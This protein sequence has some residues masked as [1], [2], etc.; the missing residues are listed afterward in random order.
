LL[1]GAKKV[2]SANRRAGVGNEHFVVAG[3]PIMK[4][5][6]PLHR[7][8]QWIRRALTD[9]RLEDAPDAILVCGCGGSNVH[10]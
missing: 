8:R 5:I 6:E 3:E 1:V 7:P 9:D 2:G 4:R 10:G